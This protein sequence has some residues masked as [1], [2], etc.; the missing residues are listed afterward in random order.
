MQQ[1]VTF[2]GMQRA[3]HIHDTQNDSYKPSGGFK[4]IIIFTK[5]KPTQII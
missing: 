5:Y 2:N 4:T 1:L 3:A